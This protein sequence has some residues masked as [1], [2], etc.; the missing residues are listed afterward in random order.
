M[1]GAP[2]IARPSVLRLWLV[3]AIQGDVL[4]AEDCEP[5]TRFVERE[6]LPIDRAFRGTGCEKP[7]AVRDAVDGDGEVLKIRGDDALGEVD[8]M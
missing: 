2:G 4:T 1:F 5:V 7:T 6:A 8:R 3:D